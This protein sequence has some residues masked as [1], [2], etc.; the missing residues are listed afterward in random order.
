MGHPCATNPELWFG[1][2]DDDGGDG[3]AKAR[4]YERSATEAPADAMPAPLPLGPAA[5]VRPARDHAPRRDTGRISAISWQIY[6]R[7]ITFQSQPE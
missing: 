6:P 4:A 3:A 5:T 7:W 2:P 1:Y